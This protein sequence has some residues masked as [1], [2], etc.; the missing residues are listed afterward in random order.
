VSNVVL[1]FCCSVV[2]HSP[3]VIATHWPRTSQIDNSNMEL[4]SN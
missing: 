2:L 1:L 3:N 4:K